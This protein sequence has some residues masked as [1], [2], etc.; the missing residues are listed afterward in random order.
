MKYTYFKSLKF[1]TIGKSIVSSI[2]DILYI[3]KSKFSK[4]VKFIDI[5]NLE[6]INIKNFSRLRLTKYFNDSIYGFQKIIIRKNKF[7]FL[8]LPLT[9]IFF[10]FLYLSIPA[11]YKYD[12]TEI[13]KFICQKQ[14]IKCE[15]KGKT[16]YTFFPTPR[17]ILK[18]VIVYDFFNKKNN[19]I[20]ANKVIIKLSIKNLLAKD[21]HKIKKIEIKNYQ[22]DLNTKKIKEFKKILGKEISFSPILF[23][24]GKIIFLN[25]TD[26]VATIN[27][28]NLDLKEFE[29]KKEIKL[30]GNFLNDDLNIS[31]ISSEN[32]D[33]TLTDVR[34]K[35][36]KLNLLTEITL[37]DDKINNNIL[38]KKDKHKF[39]GIFDVKKNEININKSNIR[40]DFLDGKLVGV[41]KFSPY[42]NFDLNLDLNSFNFKKLYNY[43]LSLNNENQVKIFKINKKI[44][45]ILNLSA[46]KVYSGYNLI[47]SFE[48]RLKFNN[49]N[50]FFEQLLFNLG[51]LGAADLIGEI[52][53]DK[54]FTNFKYESNIFVDNPRKFLSKFGI[55]NRKKISSNLFVS[56]NFDF[57]NKRISFYELSD[58]SELKADDIS[59]IENEFNDLM[60]ED[61]Y[62]NLFNFIKFKTFLKSILNDI[63]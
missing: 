38:I 6:K 15:I 25:G 10:G 52:N 33:K 51:Q 43:F 60:M 34:L 2:I 14:N 50:L 58:D 62:T 56:G 30:K 32:K 13:K 17:L 49:G 9:I 5:K 29:N 22:I 44:N 61:G 59:F 19:L 40:N 36:N 23:A 7:L 1:S 35:M 42:F 54:K 28:V 63:N 41:V 16:K 53:N 55:Y 27:N 24:G 26:Y 20:T 21:K 47:K 37:L 8:H 3:L 39:V 11:L 4:I 48:S 18:N 12:N 31:I 57:K 46:D 45:G